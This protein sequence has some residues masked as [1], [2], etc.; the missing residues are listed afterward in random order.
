MIQ[1]QR[2]NRISSSFPC[3][4]PI[5]ILDLIRLMFP[6]RV[7]SLPVHCL[8][9]SFLSLMVFFFSFLLFYF[10]FF[11]IFLFFFFFFFLYCDGA[12][13]FP[14]FSN[15]IIVAAASFLIQSSSFPGFP[16]ALAFPP[17]PPRF[18]LLFFRHQFKLGTFAGSNNLNPSVTVKCF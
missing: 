11:L 5:Y 18:P 7:H 15:I 6:L 17:P 1:F 16:L 4:R 9:L 3:F 12:A 8:S 14:S 10:L 2:H 13:A